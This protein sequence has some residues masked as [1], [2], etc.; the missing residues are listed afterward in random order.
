MAHLHGGAQIV[1]TKLEL[2]S[3]WLPSQPWFGA[4]DPAVT[5][6]GA[7]RF[8]DPDGEVGIETHLVRDVLGRTIQVPLTYRS[9]PITGG[10]AW[11]TGTMD[12]SVLGPRWVYDATGDPVYAATLATTI[13]TGGT[14][15]EQVREFPDGHTE[16]SEPSVRVE[17]SG[18]QTDVGGVGLVDVRDEGDVT[19]IVTS[20]GDLLL[21]RIIDADSSVLGDLELTGT[22]ADVDEPTALVVARLA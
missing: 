22:W 4:G 15:A 11:L 6:V 9:A 10:E 7:F 19:V 17:G 8:D 2:I 5:L 1:P 16:I 21:R 18:T 14:Q 3:A 13:L 12:H 20:V